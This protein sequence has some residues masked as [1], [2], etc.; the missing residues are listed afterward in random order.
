MGH[1]FYLITPDKEVPEKFQIEYHGHVIHELNPFEE[2]WDIL[3]TDV[4]HPKFESVKAK[5]KVFYLGGLRLRVNEEGCP[6]PIH[7]PNQ[8]WNF[9]AESETPIDI[10]AVSNSSLPDRFKLYFPGTA[11]N[12]VDLGRRTRRLLSSNATRRI[13][14]FARPKGQ[15]TEYILEALKHVKT[16]HEIVCFDQN[17]FLR[18]EPPADLFTY[19]YPETEDELIE[20]YNEIDIFISL[21]PK[22]GFSYCTAE[23]IRCGCLAICGYKG[24]SHFREFATIVQPLANPETIAS[25]I[26]HALQLPLEEFNAIRTLGKAH[27]SAATW[28]VAAY[29]YLSIALKD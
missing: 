10:L 26:D 29:T 6:Y 14:F 16:E 13:G 27:I 2:G 4:Y 24:T 3:Q 5:N 25:V 23:A 22:A 9:I 17:P 18:I 15:G 21:E 20:T 1:D 12:F 11:S 8:G 7:L 28:E 19:V